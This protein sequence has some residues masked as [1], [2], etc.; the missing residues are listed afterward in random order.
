M[1]SALNIFA[2]V[3]KNEILTA[4]VALGKQFS[5]L[6]T[7]PNTT[8]AITEA[9][10]KNN[11][12][13]AENTTFALNAWSKSL[14]KEKVEKWLD[15][16]KPTEKSKKVGIIMAGNVPLTGLHDLL[17][18]LATGNIA[19]VKTS[20]QDE[21]LINM[22]ID[23]LV[24]IEPKLADKIIL[25]EKLHNTD[26]VIATGS[27]NSARHFEYYF[28]NI[29][30]LL[31]KNKNS[32]AIVTGKETPEEYNGLAKDIFTYFGLGCRNITHVFLPEGYDPTLLYPHFEFFSDIALQH[33]YANNYNYHK[34]I[35]L[36]NLDKFFDN[37]FL[38]LKQSELL[39]SPV[40]ILH[41]SF[42]HSLSDLE[43]K[44][45]QQ[46]DNIQCIEGNIKSLCSND[47]GTSQKPELWDY[48]DGVNTLDFLTGL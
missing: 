19:I 26:A 23:F 37:G 10:I 32:V 21:V 24:R 34:A 42:Y 7:N 27:N 12:F 43:Q 47:F 44:I 16:I 33:R 48:A 2:N 15:N 20:S 18:V 46:Q 1:W 29:P 45:K 8:S 9:Y 41:Y 40:A 22:A 3:N 11:W 6:A 36:M 17:C 28:R 30:L 25:T 4:I 13:T 31:R 35:L 38:I 39:Y 14:T 5:K